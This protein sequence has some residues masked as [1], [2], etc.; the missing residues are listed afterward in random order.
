MSSEG[1]SP[2]ADDEETISALQNDDLED[3]LGT[4]I[5]DD[6]NYDPYTPLHEVATPLVPTDALE[7]SKYRPPHVSGRSESSHET[8]ENDRLY[9]QHTSSLLEHVESPQTSQG[10]TPTQRS[11]GS[12]S[13]FDVKSPTATNAL[14]SDAQEGDL[15]SMKHTQDAT[16]VN[17]GCQTPEIKTEEQDDEVLFIMSNTLDEI[18]IISDDEDTVVDPVQNQSVGQTAIQLASQTEVNMGNSI[19]RT[20][21]VQKATKKQMEMMKQAQQMLGKH[22][23]R[24][25]VTGGAGNIFK[26]TT[27]Q[28]YVASAIAN[29]LNQAE[30]VAS[31]N[32]NAWMDERMDDSDDS[33][34]SVM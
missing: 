15:D 1:D 12:I 24:K 7:Q 13:S 6:I 27:G 26:G 30:A 28:G 5:E 10:P 17:N 18:I 32:E 16:T 11:R 19:L 33:V 23:N 2:G 22:L 9:I 4:Q 20:R 21:K 8:I 29:T 34:S 31:T 3:N 25:A 14:G